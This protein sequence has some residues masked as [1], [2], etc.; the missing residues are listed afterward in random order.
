MN[1]STSLFIEESTSSSVITIEAT[2]TLLQ[3]EDLDTKEPKIKIKKR[4][5][6]LEKKFKGKDK[7]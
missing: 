1:M 7:V 5:S 3:E 6:L 4:F 2:T